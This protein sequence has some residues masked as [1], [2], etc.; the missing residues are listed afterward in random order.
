MSSTPRTP[1]GSGSLFGEASSPLEQSVNHLNAEASHWKET[2]TEK[3][4]VAL[5]LQ[6]SI[7]AYQNYLNQVRQHFSSCFLP[8]TQFTTL[9]AA[10]LDVGE[11]A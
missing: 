6:N 10:Q 7:Q 3:R 8:F 2:V 1:A 11:A 4:A 9:F 5:G